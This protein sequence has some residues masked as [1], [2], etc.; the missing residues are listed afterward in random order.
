MRCVV[1]AYMIVTT[2]HLIT[3]R[4]GRVSRRVHGTTIIKDINARAETSMKAIEAEWDG[5]HMHVVVSQLFQ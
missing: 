4:D 5:V 2:T 1:L 3:K